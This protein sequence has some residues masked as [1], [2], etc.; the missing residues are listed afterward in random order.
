M[1]LIGENV[2]NDYV[3]YEREEGIDYEICPRCKEGKEDWNHIWICE[4]NEMSVREIIE[5]SIYEYEE[6]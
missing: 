3:L 5:Q 6:N 4:R 2:K 1:N